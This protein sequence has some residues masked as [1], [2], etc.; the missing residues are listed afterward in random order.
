WRSDRY[1]QGGTFFETADHPIFGTREPR[2]YQSRR[3]GTFEYAIP[4][5]PGVYEMRLHFAET[6]YG[7]N[8]VA[9]GGEASR[10]FNVYI[11]GKAALHEFDVSNE[12]V[13]SAA[14]VRAFK[15]ISPG[16][17]GKV[18]LKFEPF[19]NPPILCAIEITPGTPGTLKPIRMIALDRTYT[20]RQGRVW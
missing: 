7:E 4:L 3:E 9:G 16:P 17:D 8:N 2:I 18:H 10:V 6:L 11:N 12:A 14:D 5:A 1:F 15:D 20:D 19:S 13:P